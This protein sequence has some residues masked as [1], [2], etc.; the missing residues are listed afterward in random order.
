MSISHSERIAAPFAAVL[1]LAFSSYASAHSETGLHADFYHGVVHPLSGLDHVAV[2]LGVGM[3]AWLLAGKARWQL[4]L[5]F[6]LIMAGSAFAASFVT[7]LPWVESAIALSV[8]AMGLLLARGKT[9]SI[10]LALPLVGLF[11]LLHGYAHSPQM[12]VSG[13]GLSYGAGFILATAALHATGLLTGAGLSQLGQLPS[14]AI[15]RVAGI[16]M[17][18]L[19]IALLLGTLP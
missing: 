6:V 9:L 12:P 2:M 1:M 19:G 3:L 16:G 13:S 11:A 18:V 4:P 5:A 17:S 15:S 14:L 8:V 7:G 10:A